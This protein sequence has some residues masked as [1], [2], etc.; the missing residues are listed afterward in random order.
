MIRHAELV[1]GAIRL[2]QAKGGLAW[3]SPS[4]RVRIVDAKGKA[5]FVHMG[6]A[7]LADVIGVVP[8]GVQSRVQ[9]IQF[10]P[11]A[12]IAIV[13]ANVTTLA[14]V[15]RLIAVECKAGRDPVRPAQQRTLDELRKRGALVIICRD[16]LQ[17]LAEGLG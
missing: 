2:I 6:R 8:C 17:A 13:S 3:K 4:G 1:I 14:T 7:G 16:S 11:N 12:N 15:G 5:R 9:P 10:N